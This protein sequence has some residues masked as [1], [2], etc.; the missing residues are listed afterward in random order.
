[1]VK[2]I[3]ECVLS[4]K[5]FESPAQK[6]NHEY[7]YICTVCLLY[8]HSVHVSGSKP[9]INRC[10]YLDRLDFCA[11]IQI[12]LRVQCGRMASLLTTMQNPAMSF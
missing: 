7:E 9:D 1:M 12:V 8:I 3:E 4:S 10:I 2:T 5:Y 11:A 6:T